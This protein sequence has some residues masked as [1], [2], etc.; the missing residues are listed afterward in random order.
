[1]ALKDDKLGEEEEEAWPPPVVN[2]T[3]AARR[4]LELA[5]NTSSMSNV[6]SLIA[7]DDDLFGRTDEATVDT[8]DVA[9]AT[10]PS[11]AA[12]TVALVAVAVEADA[13]AL[14]LLLRRLEGRRNLRG[15]GQSPGKDEV[16]K[17]RVICSWLG[18]GIVPQL[19]PEA[20]RSLSS[21]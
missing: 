14:C 11:N 20:G 17:P 21:F 18:G 13:W 5:S 10:A 16:E 2:L 12:V 6:R 7:P 1:M 3:V 8:A 9:A 19:E 15:S 4:A